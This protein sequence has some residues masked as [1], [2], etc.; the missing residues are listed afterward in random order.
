MRACGRGDSGVAL[1]KRYTLVRVQPGVP[2][3][4]VQWK[5]KGLE[6]FYVGS[7]PALGAIVRAGVVYGAPADL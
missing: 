7:I 2:A 1:L 5:D 6:A 4:V 3:E